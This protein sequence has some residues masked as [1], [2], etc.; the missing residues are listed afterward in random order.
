KNMSRRKF[1]VTTAGAGAALV[2]GAKTSTLLAQSTATPI[3]APTATPAPLP[4][5]AAGKLTVIHKTEY[6]EQVQTM[7]RNDVIK[8]A[9]DRK[10]QL[11]ISTANPEIFGDFTARM[12][13]AV[14]AGNPPDL[15]YHVLSIPQMYA[16][17]IVEDVSDVVDQAIKKYG[18]VFPVIA[19]FN[20]KINDK[21]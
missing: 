14:Q 6:F 20:G 16:L 1:L 2:A 8:F 17:D 4:V 5:G 21:W 9:A 19:E 3:P 10:I 13:A 18:A 7:F 15:G 12:A 11:D